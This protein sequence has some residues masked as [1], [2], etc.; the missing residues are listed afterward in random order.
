[1]GVRI[2]S[3]VYLIFGICIQIAEA[4]K[5]SDITLHSENEYMLQCKDEKMIARVHSE[6]DVIRARL[7]GN[8][9]IAEIVMSKEFSNEARILVTLFGALRG[10]VIIRKVHETE[11]G[12]VPQNGAIHMNQ[13][14]GMVKNAMDGGSESAI[15]P[16]DGRD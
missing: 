4:G 7:G 3:I 8:A 15:R 5:Y 6:I 13:L 9:S 1:M 16:S 14:T 2:L 11:D 10:G 12:G